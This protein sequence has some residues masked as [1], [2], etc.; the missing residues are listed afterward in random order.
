MTRPPPFPQRR[1]ELG[2]EPKNAQKHSIYRNP[3]GPPQTQ[4][5]STLFK[6]SCNSITV[7]HGRFSESSIFTRNSQLLL[8]QPG[9]QLAS[10]QVAKVKFMERFFS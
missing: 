10:Q 7:E 6:I 8:S 3:S 1:L 4:G 2:G 9:S 5:F